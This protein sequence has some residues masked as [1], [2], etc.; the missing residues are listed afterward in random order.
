MRGRLDGAG[1]VHSL[2]LDIGQGGYVAGAVKTAAPVTLELL[3]GDGKPMRRLADQQSGQIDFRIVAP[4]D[5]PVLRL[6]NMGP[7]K[8]DFEFDLQFMV[9]LADQGAPSRHYQSPAIASAAQDLARG[10][11]TDGFWDRVQ[12]DGTPLIEPLNEDEVIMT[13]VARGL[14]RNGRI[15]GAP[16]NDH[17]YLERLG[18]SDIWFKSFVVPNSS[19]L[20]YQIARDVPEFDADFRSQRVALLATI[21]AD[22]FNQHPWPVDAPDAFNQD[23]V[24]ELPDAPDQPGMN[25]TTA[26]KGTLETFVFNSERLGNSRDITL[27]RPYQFDP[28]N[29][30]N[31]LLILFDAK[32]Y[33]TT[34]STPR[35]LDNLIAAGKLPPVS[36]AFIANPDRAARGRELPGNPD[37]AD[38]LA[39]DLMPVLRDRFGADFAAA[40]TVLAGSS[41][42]GLASATVALSHP[43]VFGNAISMSGSFWWHPQNTPVDQG[44]FVAHQVATGPRRPI[45]FFMTAGLF[46]TGRMGGAGIVESGRHLR[47]VLIARGYD[48]QYREYAGGHDYVV[49]RGALADG[50]IGL[51]GTVSAK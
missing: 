8:N 35:I 49:W 5:Q 13:F 6:T 42:G 38:M 11:A 27:Y 41:Y 47:D 4:N 45:R 29:H 12:R 30:D 20:S 32:E 40:R 24:V 48:V 10:I 28:A 9:E 44:E 7:G 18:N 14:E 39:D 15:V 21:Q 19:R 34:V 2:I 36:V 23:S 25:G 51:F 31:V 16:S 43:D 50:L 3:D 26:H 37:F 46:E 17:E 33:L 1:D 22:P